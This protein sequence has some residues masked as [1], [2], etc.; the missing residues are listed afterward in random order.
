MLRAADP[1]SSALLRAI[2]AIDPVVAAATE[3][4]VQLVVSF[5]SSTIQAVAMLPVIR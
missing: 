5:R 4:L 3:H 2:A 1:E